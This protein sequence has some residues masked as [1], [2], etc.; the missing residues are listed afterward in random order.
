M[1]VLLRGRYSWTSR[2]RPRRRRLWRASCCARWANGRRT[3][4]WCSAPPATA[5]PTNCCFLLLRRRTMMS[6]KVSTW[7]PAPCRLRRNQSVP[8]KICQ[9]E[10]KTNNCHH[11]IVFWNHLFIYL[12]IF[13]LVW[14]FLDRRH[15]AHWLE[16]KVSVNLAQSILLQTQTQD[17]FS[18][19]GSTWIS[20]LDM[21]QFRHP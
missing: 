4:W 13:G 14:P 11:S 15:I 10:T 9:S 21:C 19:F 17:R 16:S 1:C 6:G 5:P 8:P 12:S 2:N 20:A 7:C 18:R 3:G